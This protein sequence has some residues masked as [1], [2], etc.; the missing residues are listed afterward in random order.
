MAPFSI[1][2]VL[3]LHCLVLFQS[4][5]QTASAPTT[6][7][8]VY[9]WWLGNRV[10]PQGISQNLDSLASVGFGGIHI[11]PIYGKKGELGIPLLSDSFNLMVRHTV[12]E[13]RKRNMWVDLSLGSGWPYGG[14]DV[15]EKYR[16]Q[17]LVVYMDSTHWPH[18]TPWTTMGL[19][20]SANKRDW[21]PVPDTNVTARYKLRIVSKSTYQKVKRASPGGEGYVIDHFNPEAL[22]HYAQRWMP[23]LKQLATAGGLR[24]IYMDSYEVFGAN[25]GA[26]LAT[27]FKR[28]Y[29]YELAPQLPI[30]FYPSEKVEAV[31]FRKHYHN[32]LHEQLLAFCH[33]LSNQAK[34]WGVDLRLQAH[35]APANII[36]LYETASIPETEAFG[37]KQDSIIGHEP[38]ASYES[39]RFGEPDYYCMKLASTRRH[40]DAKSLVASE[41]GTWLTEHF[42]EDPAALKLRIDE[43]FLAGINHIGF[44]GAAYQELTDSFPGRRFY[45]TLHTGPN[46]HLFRKMKAVNEYVTRCQQLLQGYTIKADVLVLF[47]PTENWTTLAPNY[48][49]VHMQETHFAKQWMSKAMEAGELLRRHGIPFRYI[50]PAQLQTLVATKH[51]Y[52]ALLIPGYSMVHDSV[53][54][55]IKHNGLDGIPIIKIGDSLKQGNRSITGGYEQMSKQQLPAIFSKVYKTMVKGRGLEVLT[56][57]RAGHSHYFL[58]NTNQHDSIFTIT[59]PNGPYTINFPI[60]N[61]K[62]QRLLPTNGNQYRFRLASGSSC[63]IKPAGTGKASLAVYH[64]ARPATL[65]MP[66]RWTISSAR[67]SRLATVNYQELRTYQPPLENHKDYTPLH[68]TT[69]FTY[70]GSAGLMVK[71]RGM[72][73]T[74]EV[75][76][77]G[78]PVGT[79][80][81]HP[82]TCFIPHDQLK[83]GANSLSIQVWPHDWNRIIN[84][85]KQ[86]PEWK[87]FEDINF[88][89]IR[90]KPF[91]VADSSYVP[92]GVREVEIWRLESGGQR[93]APGIRKS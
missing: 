64:N 59:L 92:V 9:W 23:L 77:N 79:V 48:R 62:W 32:L 35:G 13:A 60:D 90:Y 2:L 26:E 84:Y 1:L 24:S 71:L 34:A 37:T 14:P 80:W 87:S 31:N 69:K 53:V 36:D 88:V 54:S 47:D 8:Y 41:T 4:H 19:Y 55:M 73:Q 83:R 39:Q 50:S 28:R 93:R 57:E 70:S 61:N 5:G 12:S 89:N 11:I 25:Y 45:A 42:R 40:H 10:S 51:Q 52:K 63:F 30:L 38:D 67:G 43:L 81:A 7:P 33:S 85:E 78:R 75:M 56:L 66:S 6:K 15:P 46:G 18:S 49:L 22:E 20:A 3:V 82:K 72:N 29:G 27:K 58:V 21:Q 74:A 44:H 16:A 76:L 86:H 65:I 91:L 68:Y 17:Q